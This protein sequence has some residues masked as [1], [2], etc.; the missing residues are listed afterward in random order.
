MGV[1]HNL[2]VL[3]YPRHAEQVDM[4]LDTSEIVE[5]RSNNFRPFRLG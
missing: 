1:K 5:V 2:D 3:K 4:F